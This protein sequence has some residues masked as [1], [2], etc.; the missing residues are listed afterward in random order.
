MIEDCNLRD[1]NTFER[2]VPLVILKQIVAD[3]KQKKLRIVFTNGC[4][5][6]I[7][8]GHIRYLTNPELSEMFREAGFRDV[9]TI[10]KQDR[11]FQKK[12]VFASAMIVRGF[13]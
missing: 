12:K 5:D 13:K 3:L 2:I 9:E 1:I 11:L 7:H 10:Y 8:P 4:F 6:L